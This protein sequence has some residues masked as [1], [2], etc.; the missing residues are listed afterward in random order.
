MEMSH[1]FQ[2]RIQL[3]YKGVPTKDKWGRMSNQMSPFESIDLSKKGGGRT[4]ESPP[5]VHQFILH[6]YPFK[7]NVHE[8]AFDIN[9]KLYK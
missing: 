8:I 5:W 7:T 4:Q 6:F 1:T 2:G 9:N 3:I